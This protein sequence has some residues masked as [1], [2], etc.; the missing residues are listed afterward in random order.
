MTTTAKTR[1]GGGTELAPRRKARK[2]S[3]ACD[4]CKAK[5]SRCNGYQPCQQC[6]TRGRVC[7]YDA[8]Y[9]R[10]RARTPPKGD[11]HVGSSRE[12]GIGEDRE[13]AVTEVHGAV[14]DPTSCL[15][16]LQ[17]VRKRCTDDE[18]KPTAQQADAPLPEVTDL[19]QCHLPS[20]AESRRL[21][22]LFF[23]LCIATYHVLHRPQVESWLK[24][25]EDNAKSGIPPWSHIGRPKAAIVVAV[26]AHA[27][28]HDGKAKHASDKLCAVSLRLVDLDPDPPQLASAQARF[29]QVLYLL[30]TSRVQR[31]WLVFGHVLQHVST[32]GLHRAR[33]NITGDNLSRQLAIRTFWSAYIL[34]VHLGTAFGRPRHFHDDDIDQVMPDNGFSIDALV[35][36]AQFV[37]P[38]LFRPTLTD[39]NCASHRPYHERGVFH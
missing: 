20:P 7:S 32:L 31:G 14:V 10:G 25:T 21:V 11:A 26:L 19:D 9:T 4:A 27:A 18:N 33:E 17:R 39:K 12:D 24:T 30:T 37:S 2:V 28:V 35:A 8:A 16:F 22:A 23:D 38:F 5:K 15:S 1:V 34:D 13:L 6:T 29:V 3:R 36:H